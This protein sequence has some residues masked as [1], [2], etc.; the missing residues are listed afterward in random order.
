MADS[1]HVE[2]QI[3]MQCQLQPLSEGNRGINYILYCEPAVLGWVKNYFLNGSPGPQPPLLS[4]ICSNGQQI[5]PQS[6]I[7]SEG[8]CWP[9]SICALLRLNIYVSPA[10]SKIHMLN[11]NPLCDGFGQG[12]K[13]LGH[14][15]GAIMNAVSAPTKETQRAPS[16]LPPLE[17]H[18]E[19]TV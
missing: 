13:W 1:C 16:S 14:E 2:T 15:G 10:P 11:L 3:K 18:W 8:L 19:D 4:A 6:I 17:T 12:T 7:A 5:E 9:V